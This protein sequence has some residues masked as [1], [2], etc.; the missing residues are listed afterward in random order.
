MAPAVYDIESRVRQDFVG[1]VLVVENL[2][3][4]ALSLAIHVSTYDMH[5]LWLRTAVPVYEK[6]TYK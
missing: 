3:I 4:L 5:S 2:Q 1:V 6:Y